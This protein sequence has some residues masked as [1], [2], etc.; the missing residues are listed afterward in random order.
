MKFA[1]GRAI[2]HTRQLSYKEE[3]GCSAG[4]P[5]HKYRD[6]VIFREEEISLLAKT[7]CSHFYF[8]LLCRAWGRG[9]KMEGAAG[10][11]FSISLL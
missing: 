4:S 3:Q 9:E 1:W 7:L 6:I 10:S 2:P 8:E 11:A 5:R